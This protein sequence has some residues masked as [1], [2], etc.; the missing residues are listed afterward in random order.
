VFLPKTY[1]SRIMGIGS[2]QRQSMISF[3]TYLG[4]TAVGFIS[5]MYFAH[6]LGKAVLGTYYLFLAYYGVFDLIADGGFGGAAVKRISEGKE[7]NEYYSAYLFLRICL[8]LLA[9]AVLIAGR[10]YLKGLETI[11]IF[12]GLI[13]ALFIGII[14]SGAVNGIVGTGKVGVSQI[15]RMINSF[16]KVFIQIISVFLGYEVGGLIGGFI[17]GL[18]VGSIINFHFLKL[19]LTWFKKFH[20]RSLFIFSF[21]SFLSSSGYIAFS[22]ADTLIIGFIM[23]EDSVGIYQTAFQLTSAAT[24]IAIALHTVLYPK[25]S[26]WNTNGFLDE[27]SISLARAITYSLLLAVPVAVGGWILGDRLLYYFYGAGFASGAPALAILLLV[28]IVNVFMYLQTMCL[29][30]IDRP[31]ES[32]YATGTAAAVNIF[33][34]LSLIPLLGIVGAA[35]ATLIAMLVNVAIARHYLAKQIPV[36]LERGPTLHILFAAGAMAVV[37]LLYRLTIPLT[38]VFL[39]LGAV[40]L[41]GIV[42]GFILLK[43]DAGLHDEIMNLVVQFGAPWP[44]WL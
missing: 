37:I 3:L 28:Q 12:Y 24:F 16:V 14:Y 40:A 32:F 8:L 7:Q 19:H 30:A 18:I 34:D 23:T 11:N 15:S 20:V 25:V 5:T 10:P 9:I 4:L 39:V 21:W 44:R 26:N 41:G 35:I 22:Y 1:L 2:V 6:I 13:I 29:N 33:L 43:A 38:N 42:Y 31:K 36:R 27:I 17:L